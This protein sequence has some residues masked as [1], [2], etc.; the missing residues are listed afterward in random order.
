MAQESRSG[1][2]SIPEQVDA[3][4]ADTV[5]WLRTDSQSAL[6]AVAI[7]VSLYFVFI[8]LR[9]GLVRLLGG[10]GDVTTWQGFAGRII[11]R[12]RTL[13]MAALAAYAVVHVLAPPGPLRA[14]IDFVFTVA[15]AIQG[16]VWLR[17]IIL[18]VVERR[19]EASDDP[20]GFASALG[21]IR[22]LVNVAVWAL[23]L[24]LILDNLG[25]N[26]T[27][28]VAGLGVGGIAIGLAAQGIFSDLFAALSILFDR[29]FKVG[30]LIQFGTQTGRVEA[31]GLKTVRLRLL[32]GEQLVVG[33]TQLLAQQISNLRRVESR[34][35]AL[36]FGVTYQTPPEM[37]ARLS[38][39]V[40]SVVDAVPEARF[41]RCFFIG[42][43]ASSLDFE[44]IFHV[45]HEEL[46]VMLAARHR[47]GIG[48]LQRFAELGVE[49]AY[50]THTSFTAA[51]D[52]TLIDPRE[53]IILKE[54]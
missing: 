1:V 31:I 49:F 52:G 47:V 45:D 35:V 13:F 21:I 51:P 5:S 46:P 18:A 42:F 8:G 25:V 27:A 9:W 41:D 50:P 15:F 20:G 30:D 10:S 39:E 38:D 2:R 26:V 43:G 29:P 3:L 11:R 53:R 17:E 12:T 34:R 37:M 6:L 44:L 36:L 33:N 24:I 16:A 14:A 48:L 54:E 22:V 32:S 28:L 19:A 7:A 4:T 40:R 23:A